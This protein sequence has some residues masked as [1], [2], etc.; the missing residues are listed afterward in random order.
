MI[1]EIRQ[2]IACGQFELSRHAVD[3]SLLRHI[4][5]QELREAIYNGEII[6]DYPD[7]KYGPSCLIFGKTNQGRPIH[8][9]C[10]YPSRPL[11]KIITLYQ[12]APRLWK[13]FRIRR[14]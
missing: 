6:E 9:Q 11:V 3:Q 8:V 10:S 4:S 7:D 5:V 12:P 2:K 1:E 13:G 14:R